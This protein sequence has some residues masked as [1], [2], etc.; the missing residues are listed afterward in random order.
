MIELAGVRCF[1][2][3]APNQRGKLPSSDQA[4]DRQQPDAPESKIARQLFPWFT[5]THFNAKLMN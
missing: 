2:W 3:T 5:R 1:G 4:V